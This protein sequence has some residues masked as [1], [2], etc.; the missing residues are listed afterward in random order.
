MMKR[1]RQVAERHFGHRQLEEL[2]AL[3]DHDGMNHQ[4]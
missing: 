2:P 1:S 3:G 4:H